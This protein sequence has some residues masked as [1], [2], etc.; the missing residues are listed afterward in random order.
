MFL[1]A[2]LVVPVVIIALFYLGRMN[3]AVQRVVDTDL[4]LVR[5]GDRISFTLAQARRNEKNYLLYRDSSYLAGARAALDLATAI[6]RRGSRLGPGAA[7]LFRAINHD[8]AAYRGQLDTLAALPETEFSTAGLREYAR[9]RTEHQMLLD[10]ARAAEDSVYR[11]SLVA[12]A[13]VLSAEMALPRRAG[14]LG[15]FLNDRI[16]AVEDRLTARTDSVISYAV[17]RTRESQ[18]RAR[19]LSAWGQRNIITVF[20]LVLV[21]LGWLVASVPNRLVIPVKR[22]ANALARAEQGDLAVHVPLTTHDELGRLARQLNRV[23]ARL[24]EFDELKV[25]RILLLERRFRLLANDLAEGVIV[26]DRAPSIVFANAAVGVLLGCPSEEAVGHAL[27]EF[28]RLAPL[29]ETLE[30]TLAGATSHRECELIPGMPG[31]AV[32]I[33]ALR[34]KSGTVVGALVVITNPAPPEQAE[35]EV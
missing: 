2:A 34:D 16:R 17:G 3:G 7:A 20:L 19:R 18:E 26:V 27:A 29:R 33:E 30:H 10:M 4:E 1:S 13:E 21:L 23:F 11:D 28:P 35:T 24:R 8:V 25:N 5:I 31:S 6:C 22:I 14:L 9:L 15:Q 32:C 12:A